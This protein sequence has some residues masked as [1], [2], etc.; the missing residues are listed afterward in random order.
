MLSAKPCIK[1]SLM[2]ARRTANKL[3]VISDWNWP[4]AGAPFLELIAALPTINLRQ[5]RLL[6]S[7]QVESGMPLASLLPSF[8]QVLS[9][10]RSTQPG[11]H[12][13]AG[14][15]V[16]PNPADARR[17]SDGTSLTGEHPFSGAGFSATA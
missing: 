6:W 9:A 17:V 15:P 8:R 1:Q 2:L 4:G 5:L 11:E 10:C 13:A 14:R 16:W 12:G 3:P 7:G